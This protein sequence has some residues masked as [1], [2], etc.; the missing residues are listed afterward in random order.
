MT[1]KIFY[2]LYLKKN[3]FS[4]AGLFTFWALDYLPHSTGDI[5]NFEDNRQHWEMVFQAAAHQWTASYLAWLGLEACQF[6]G[7]SFEDTSYRAQVEKEISS[8]ASASLR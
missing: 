2:I 4:L 6:G 1:W 5:D 7:E 8:S 3:A